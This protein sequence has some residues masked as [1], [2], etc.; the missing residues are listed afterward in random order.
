MLRVA[1]TFCLLLLASCEAIAGIPDV[2]NKAPEGD[3]GP[4]PGPGGCTAFCERATELCTQEFTIYQSPAACATACALYSDD[5]RECR[6]DALTALDE[7]NQN[8]RYLYCPR[9]SLG[10]GGTC[11]GSQ[12]KNYCNA[13]SRVCSEYREDNVNYPDGDPMHAEECETKCAVIPDKS[14]ALLGPGESSFDVIAD[15]EGDTLQCRLVH[16]TL[17]S[18]SAM[19][20][21]D[22]CAHAYISPQ[23]MNGSMAPW[24]GGPN[25]PKGTPTCDDYCAVNLAACKDE[26]KVYDNLAQCRAACRSFE[27]G[28]SAVNEPGI[29]SVACRKYHSY[30][31]AVYPNGP[32]AHCP[33]AGPGGA[34]VCGDDCESFCQ[35]LEDGCS[36][37]YEAEY[38]GSASDCRSK[39][40]A[41]RKADTTTRTTA[42]ATASPTPKPATRSRVGC[43][44]RPSPPR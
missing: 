11:G 22:H 44:T 6:E 24:C 9:A 37:E 34:Q 33:H 36:A 41:A 13:I 38:G 26:F 25:D 40:D 4:T 28:T 7:S 31:A 1:L 35:L 15:H 39:C 27:L 21:K 20:A 2:R 3:G 14:K 23:P 18:Q 5:E 19:F 17:A 43:T 10:G 8:E 42:R 30:N 29:N 16:L 32:V 12:C